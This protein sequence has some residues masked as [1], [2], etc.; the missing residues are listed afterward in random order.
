MQYFLNYRYFSGYKSRSEVL[1][2]QEK[3]PQDG[4]PSRWCFIA[5][6]VAPE[7]HFTEAVDFIRGFNRRPS[8]YFSIESPSTGV[9]FL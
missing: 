7:M 4:D 1:G 9:F 3:N 2:Y 6:V 8:T 5:F